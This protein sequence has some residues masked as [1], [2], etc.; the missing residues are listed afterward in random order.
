MDRWVNEWV[1][2]QMDRWVDGLIGRQKN[3]WVVG[4]K[5]GQTDGSVNE[6][7]ER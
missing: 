6:K 3:R 5:D 2:G 7:V 4:W 1:G